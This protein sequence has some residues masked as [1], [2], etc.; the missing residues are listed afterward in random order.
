MTRDEAGGEAR[1]E[2]PACRTQTPARESGLR[3]PVPGDGADAIRVRAVPHAE[4]C[5]PA[6]RSGGTASGGAAAAVPD[7]VKVLAAHALASAVTAARAATA[8]TITAAAATAATAAA[9]VATTAA[10][11]VTA[12]AAAAAATTA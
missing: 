6:G 5:D 12:A 1:V 11:A 10:A 9:G 7:V 8:A 4:T 3:R 2:I